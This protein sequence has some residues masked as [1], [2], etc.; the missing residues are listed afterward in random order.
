M[1]GEA[2]GVFEGLLPGEGVGCCEGEEVLETGARE[3][4][5]E[6]SLVGDNEGLEVG[7]VLNCILGEIEG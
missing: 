6:E 7:L 5:F 4:F 2:V 3:I 1:K